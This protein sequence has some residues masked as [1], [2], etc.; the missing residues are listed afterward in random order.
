[1]TTSEGAVVEDDEHVDEEDGGCEVCGAAGADFITDLE[2]ESAGLLCVNC[3]LAEK[4]R[5]ADAD[6]AE[7]VLSD[8]HWRRV[9]SL[10][11]VSDAWP[12][13]EKP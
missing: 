7:Q 6:A 9:R 10:L 8:A 13:E 11:G 3:A 12:E 2:G 5:R 1:M 4:Q